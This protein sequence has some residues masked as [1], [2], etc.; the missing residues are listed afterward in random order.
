VETVEISTVVYLPPEEVFAFLVDFPRYS[1][2]SKYLREVVQNGDGGPGTTYR[3]HFRWWKL[4]YTAHTVVT[5]VDAPSTLDWEV[6][7]DLN[8]HGQWVVEEVPEEAPPDRETACIVRL[9]VHY[10]PNTAGSS[11]LDLPRFISFDW[12]IDR[13]MGLIVEEGER[14]VERIVADLEGE[15]REVDLTIAQR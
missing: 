10:D 13:V 12:V 15:R 8:A 11:I 14:V 4:W 9:V 6:T 3:L 1:E 2:Y 5:A 7:R